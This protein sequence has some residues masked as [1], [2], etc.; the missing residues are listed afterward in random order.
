MNLRTLLA[1]LALLSGLFAAPAS[2]LT[3]TIFTEDFENLLQPPV[4]RDM[5]LPQGGFFAV[6]GTGD[7]G[8]GWTLNGGVDFIRELSTGA[9]TFGAIDSISIDM[10][11]TP[12]P[13]TLSHSFLAEAGLTYTLSWDWFRNGPGSDLEVTLGSILPSKSRGPA[14][15]LLSRT[16]YLEW[17]ATT[18]GTQTF[19][20]RGITDGSNDSFGSTIDNVMLT[21]VPEPTPLTIMAAGLLVV[22]YLSR[23]RLQHR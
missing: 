2:A 23:R 8:N 9:H 12:G 1:G 16:P 14:P 13:G 5:I 21:A 19:S 18:S 4:V 22:G 10:L 7:F 3:G 17:T 15:N 6:T 20:F 11:G